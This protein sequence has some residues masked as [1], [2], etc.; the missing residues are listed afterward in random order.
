M[1]KQGGG[2]HLNLGCPG[3]TE[4]FLWC[5]RKLADGP[6]WDLGT[7]RNHCSEEMTPHLPCS[8]ALA[9]SP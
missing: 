9:L 1:G 3:E 4:P 7:Q 6:V 5:S 8:S 2:S